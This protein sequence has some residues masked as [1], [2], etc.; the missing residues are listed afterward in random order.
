[1]KKIYFAPTPWSGSNDVL[2]DYRFQTP[3][4]LGVWENIQATTNLEEAEYLI[5]Q[6]ECSDKNVLEKFEPKKRLYF[7]REALSTHLKNAYPSTE[8]NRFSFWD[9]SGYLPTRWWYGKN[10]S[11]GGINQ[12]YDQLSKLEIPQKTK[13]MSCILSNKEMNEGHRLRKEF[14]KK[15]LEKYHFD[16]YGSVS[17]S[18][19]KLENNDKFQTLKDYKYCLGFDNQDFIKDFFGTPFTDSLLSWTVPIF[20]CGQELTKYFPEGSFIQ[21]DLRK[22]D[23]EIERLIDIIENDDFEKRIPLLKEARENV[24]NKYNF[25]PTIKNVIDND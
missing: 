15:F 3:N 7:N 24:L 16:L 17:F 12:D 5:I 22:G 19:A 10:W 21:F 23:S 25:W 14:T 8:F 20:W 11:S 2:D 9:G 13:K 6:D 1:M 4:N 18:N